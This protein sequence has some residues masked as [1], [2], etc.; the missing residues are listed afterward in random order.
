MSMKRFGY[1]LL[2]VVA[3]IFGGCNK[4]EDMLTKQKDAIVRYLTSSR[5]MVAE[6]EVGNV[7]EE[8]P[9]FYTQFGQDVFRH[10]TNYYEE[11]RTEWMMVE[12]TST[13]D[14][15][16]AAYT[17]SGS[18]PNKSQLYWS[19]IPALISEIEASN[20]NKYDHLEWSEE[21]L[22][23]QLGS[24]KVIRGLEEALVGCYAQDSV[25]VYMTS[26]AAYGKH[27]LGT[28]PKESSVAWY[29]KIL[30]VTK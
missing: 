15:N 30:N 17:F 9:P 4:D 18:E 13:L 11:G 20:V 24:G 3:L 21:P 8:N 27:A 22:T 5:R 16:F 26:A 2:A 29:I 12:P 10:V 7:I 25:Q 6:E 14:I 1:I 19:N 23:V 28:V